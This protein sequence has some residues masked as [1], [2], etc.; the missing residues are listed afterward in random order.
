M[1]DAPLPKPYEVTDI[2][3]LRGMYEAQP[4]CTIRR[5]IATIDVLKEREIRVVSDV[6]AEHNK[7]ALSLCNE[8]GADHLRA[9][10]EM[11]RGA[12]VDVLRASGSQGR[13]RV[14]GA[15]SELCAKAIESL[16]L[17]EGG[18]VVMSPAKGALGRILYKTDGVMVC[19]VT[20]EPGA[21]WPE[22][23][24]PE[25]SETILRTAGRITVGLIDGPMLLVEDCFAFIEK[26]ERHTVRNASDTEPAEYI[27]V[28]RRA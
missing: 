7:S 8:I 4:D 1:S 13:N 6:V 21:A 10:A 28:M 12:C 14:F 27:S 23:A 16:P 17:P 9:G 11:M 3:L 25:H 2:E 15:F 24:H 5:L 26:S 18:Q 20:L 19:L 22:E